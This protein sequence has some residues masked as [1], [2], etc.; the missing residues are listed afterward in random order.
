VVAIVGA[1]AV[2]QAAAAAPMDAPAVVEV[3]A[4]APDGEVE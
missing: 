1:G 2:A 4:D 3:K